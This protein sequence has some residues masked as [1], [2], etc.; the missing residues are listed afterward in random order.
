MAFSMS[1]VQ[2]W[3]GEVSD[4][5]GVAAVKLERLAQAGADLAFIFTRPK[6]GAADM[7]L[8]FLAPING[9]EQVQA[10]QEAGLAPAR[11]I[12]MLCVE[13]ENRAGIG[14]Q[15]MSHLAVAG[16]ALRGMSISAVGHQ[17][18]AYLAFDNSHAATLATQC[19]A[20]LA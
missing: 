8:I 13:G 3:V 19:L 12:S 6:P 16:I 2:V 10:A 15:I 1:R 9:P 20:T 18:A 14:F 5:P 17:F 4:R 11:D 7:S